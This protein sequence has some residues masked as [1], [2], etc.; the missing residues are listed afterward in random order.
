MKFCSIIIMMALHKEEK[1]EQAKIDRINF[2][3]RKSK[4]QG[5]TQEEKDEQAALRS[6]YLEAIRRNLKST[7]DSIEFIDSSGSSNGGNE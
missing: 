6:E 2:L 4:A 1:M 3:A 7:L 5:L